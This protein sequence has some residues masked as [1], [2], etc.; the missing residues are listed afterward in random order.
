M[1]SFTRPKNSTFFSQVII[2]AIGA[3]IDFSILIVLSKYILFE[4]AFLIGVTVAIFVNYLLTI[5]YSFKSLNK[6]KTRTN[7]ITFYY[8][9]YCITV[10]VQILVIYGLQKL[11]LDIIFSKLFAICSG[12][13][14]SFILKF[15]FIFGIDSEN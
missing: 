3:A 2:G 4:I 15:F 12:F 5:K 8:L 6:I 14:I 13:I 11:N 7:E 9:S 1:N 10:L